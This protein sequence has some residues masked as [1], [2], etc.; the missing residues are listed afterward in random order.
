MG[1]VVGRMLD[2]DYVIRET[3]VMT[4]GVPQDCALLVIAGPQTDW[5]PEERDALATYIAYGGRVLALLDP[6]LQGVDIDDLANDFRQYG[7]A[8]GS[9]F[10]MEASPEHRQINAENEP[11]QFYYDSSLTLHPIVQ[12]P[13]AVWAIQMA[14]SVI[15]EGTESGGQV[16][17]TLIEA[18]G[19]SWA[20]TDQ[21]LKADALPTPDEEE[22]QGR[23]GL[24]AV[25]EITE[26]RHLVSD[27]P[28]DAK[29]RLVVF[30]D[31]DFASNRLSSLARNGDF[32]LNAVAWLVGEE[33]QLGAR[34]KGEAEFMALTGVQ[35][36]V[37]LL[38]ALVVMPGLCLGLG[39]WVLIRR[40][41][42]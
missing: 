42:G 2:Q 22:L 25:V 13:D 38:V 29:G 8:V 28:E 6:A 40:R 34:E 12:M 20:E 5:L 10:V 17:R 24:A 11:L 14:R 16:G 36:S 32:F 9:D 19:Q 4:A 27:A 31:S 33:D 39:V 7:L 18:S 35:L 3:R 21:E 15:W 37:S 30:G 26:P 41:M 1:L 23:V